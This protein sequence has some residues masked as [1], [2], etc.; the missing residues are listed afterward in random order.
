MN[1]SLLKS[2]FA[3]S[4]MTMTSRITGFIRDLVIAHVFGAGANVDAFF[5]AFRIPNFFR[6]LFGEGAFSQAFIPVL[7]EFK[8][9]G[10]EHEVKI[11]LNRIAGLMITVLFSL[12]T[13]AVILTPW[14]MWILA[15]GFMHDPAHFDL[16]VSMLR[17]TFPYILFI[18]LTAYVSGILNT[19]GRFSIPAFTPN[20]LNLALIG[21]AIFLAPHFHDPIKAL[22]WGVFIGGVAQ[23]LFQLPFLYKLNLL[24][25][26]QLLWHDPGVRRVL[27][28]M[29]PAVFGVC[30]SQISVMIDTI[31]A[32]FLP[33]GSISW[34]NYSSHLTMFPLGV[35]GVAIATVVLPHLSR[36]HAT[37]SVVEFSLALDW[38][39]RFVLVIAVPAM[40]AMLVLAGPI[41]ATLFQHGQFSEFAV[42]MSRRSLVAFSL[43]IPAFMLVKVL[44][45]GFYSRQDIRTPVKIA[46]IA[47]ISNII[48]N[49]ILIFP[50]K[51]AGLA[52]STALTSTLNAG[53]L[54]WTTRRRQF[55]QPRRGWG[56]FWF[57]LLLAASM[58]TFILF[59]MTAKLSVWFEWSIATR[60]WH[61][62]EICIAGIAVYLGC[63]YLSG[64]RWRDFVFS[65][66]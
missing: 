63:L 4:V 18:S 24:P 22:A 28:L 17:I 27:T 41:L 19:Y 15:P 7:A 10:D 13:L 45:A 3:V 2:T 36:K 6:S 65:S 60:I 9:N 1:K 58:M 14:L 8:E 23:L 11:F 54:F 33:E 40:I 64:M 57:R 39:L 50:L 5:V 31:F 53:L 56:K 29:L 43:G 34:I 46:V 21:A 37:R 12:S 59:T 16:T 49:T 62:S 47:V 30:V 48:L 38:G 26:P 35:F 55:Y 32:S 44:A 42:I 20:L 61:L 25:K 66:N 51:H 52:L